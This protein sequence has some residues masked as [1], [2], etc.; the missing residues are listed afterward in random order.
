MELFQLLAAALAGGTVL[1]FGMLGGIFTERSGVM[2]LAIEGYMLLGATISYSASASSGSPWI[3]LLIGAIAAAILG[4]LHAIICISLKADQVVSGL[5]TNFVG[6]GVSL[7]LGANLTSLVGTVPLLPSVA[8]PKLL[9]MGWLGEGLYTLTKQSIMVYIGFVLIPIAQ[10][11][12]TKTRPGMH[13]RA[14]GENPE[15]ADAMGINVNGLRYVYTILGA[16]LAGIGGAAISIA[17]Y[18]GWF[19]ELTTNGRGWICVGLVIFAQWNPVR[20]AFGA[21]FF[22]I[23]SRLVLDLKIPATLFG[24]LVANPFFLHPNYTFFLEMLPYFFT[25]VVMIIGAN[26]AKAKHIGAPSALG[27]PYSRGEKGKQ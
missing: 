20:G 8:F 17:I 13:L 12:L 9:E 22:G 26:S 7:V 21:Y 4:I 16:A 24:G 3:G 15:A 10:W 27:R 23:L 5:A 25:L 1:L 2:N 6:T 18:S 14:I 11:Y 19:S